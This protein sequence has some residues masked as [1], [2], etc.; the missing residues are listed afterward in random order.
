MHTTSS[1]AGGVAGAARRVPAC[2]AVNV[3]TAGVYLT[4]VR[5]CLDTVQAGLDSS[6]AVAAPG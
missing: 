3:A 1:T 6:A 2:A 4:S 5:V